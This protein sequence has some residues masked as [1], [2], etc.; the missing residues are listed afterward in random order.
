MSDSVFELVGRVAIVTGASSGLGERFAR[1]LNAAG[2][3]VVL[4]ARRTDR[5]DSLANELTDALVVECDLSQAGQAEM[6][7]AAAMERYQQIDILVN[8]AGVNNAA[9]AIDES[10]DDFR[11]EIE[12]N[13]IA[14]FE[15][16]RLA[17]RTMIAAERTGSIINI[18][19]IFGLVGV[20]QIPDAG[21]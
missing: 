11:H 4:A 15:L 13:L 18:A 6:L 20:G 1:I 14:P 8:N 7:V 19:S 2:A 5:L 3:R 17:A 12:V 10:L 21:Y 9:L 16:S